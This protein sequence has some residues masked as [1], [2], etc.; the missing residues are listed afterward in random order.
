[1]TI[2]DRVNVTSRFDLSQIQPPTSNYEKAFTQFLDRFL[3]IPGE[4]IK[5]VWNADTCPASHLPWLAWSFR[6]EEW[7]SVWDEATKRAVIKASPDVH[8]HKGTRFAI[9]KALGALN[10]PLTLTEWF[11]YSGQPYTFRINIDLRGQDRPWTSSDQ[12]LVYRTAIKSK[13][14]RSYLE[15]IGVKRDVKGQVGF[16]AFLKTSS[17]IRIEPPTLTEVNLPR[18]YVYMAGAWKLRTLFKIYPRS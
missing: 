11:Q 13:N 17:T 15:N 3:N 7:N 1:M 4:H 9:D 8:R 10:L 12:Q 14:V 2:P 5:D 16:G 18:P 6:V